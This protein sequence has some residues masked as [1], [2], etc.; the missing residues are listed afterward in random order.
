MRGL[1]AINSVCFGLD[2]FKNRVSTKANKPCGKRRK[3]DGKRSRKDEMQASVEKNIQQIMSNK[4][5]K[6]QEWI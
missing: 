2:Y 6:Q 5:E 3:R 4:R 1:G